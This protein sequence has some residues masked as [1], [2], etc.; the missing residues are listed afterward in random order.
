MP[1]QDLS[2]NH[3]GNRVKIQKNNKTAGRLLMA[4]GVTF[5]ITAA[6]M[7]QPAY[8]GVGCALIAVGVAV[9]KKTK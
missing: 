8:V 3:E 1:L 4:S 6:M 2:A 5:F 7:H 9:F